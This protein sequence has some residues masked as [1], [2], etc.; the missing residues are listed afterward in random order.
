MKALRVSK[1][2]YVD[3]ENKFKTGDT[4]MIYETRP[5]SKLKRWTVIEAKP[6]EQLLKTSQT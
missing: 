4:V 3:P 1:K 2:Y 5:L 6:S